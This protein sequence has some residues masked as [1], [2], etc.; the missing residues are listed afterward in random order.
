MYLIFLVHLI[1]CDC[2]KNYKTACY[3]DPFIFLQVRW[4]RYSTSE[5]VCD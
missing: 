3:T 1:Y 5:S 4:P 2:S